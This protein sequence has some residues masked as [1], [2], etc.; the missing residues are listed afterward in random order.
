MTGT[1]DEEGPIGEVWTLV[2]RD[3]VSSKTE[4]G[5]YD[6]RS[7]RGLMLSER[8]TLLGSDAEY[9]PILIKYLDVQANLSIQVH[10]DAAAAKLLGGGASS[11]TECWY[12]LDAKPDAQIYLGF[13]EGVDAN[14]IAEKLCTSDCVDVLQVHP[15]RKGDFV[16]VP[17]GT[18]HALCGGVTLVEVQ[19][20]SD[21]TY[22]VYDWG[23][24]GLDGKPREL[25]VQE[26][27]SSIDY[28]SNPPGPVQ[29]KFIDPEAI[30]PR[31]HLLGDEAP[32]SVD[33]VH[34]NEPYQAKEGKRARAI[35]VLSGTGRLCFGSHTN[36]ED[37]DTQMTGGECAIH[38]GETWLIPA[39]I[40]S[41]RLDSANGDL[42]LL[43]A[44]VDE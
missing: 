38:S 15:I 30:N 8:A 42:R 35:I 29:P 10:P 2:D 32:F 4:G 21:T 13:A 6:G 12:I 34:V 39:G 33:L 9:F 27:L 17:A 14:E 28:E 18:V 16:F 1:L 3:D 24:V 31:A 5:E 19:Q 43:E 41:Y 7:L 23:R 11:K 20:N 40:G 36:A 22:R 26:A 44:E 37:A 25:H